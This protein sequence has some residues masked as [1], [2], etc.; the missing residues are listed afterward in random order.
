MNETIK[1][2]IRHLLTLLGGAL[3]AKGWIDDSLVEALIG[4]IF[5]LIGGLC[6]A[7]NEYRAGSIKHAL[8]SALR[9]VAS[10]VGAFCIVKGYITE[11]TAT[12]I[13]SVIAAIGSAV[14]GIDDEI[15]A[16]KT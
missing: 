6:G 1:S 12:L 2:I 3:A 14:W 7:Y 4:I 8:F 9:H 16:A 5:A 15:E 11:E 13:I 10:A